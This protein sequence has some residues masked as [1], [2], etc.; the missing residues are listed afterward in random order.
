MLILYTLFIC[1]YYNIIIISYQPVIILTLLSTSV[2]AMDFKGNIVFDTTK[3]DGQYKKTACND[4]LMG[5]LPDF[6]FTTIQE[7]GIHVYRCMC[8]MCVYS[9]VYVCV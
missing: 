3:S 2:A 5:L 6:H 1:T 9:Y 7:V 8:S 4:K